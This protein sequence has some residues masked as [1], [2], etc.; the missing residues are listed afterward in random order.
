MIIKIKQ[1]FNRSYFDK[2][3]PFEY[4]LYMVFFFVTLIIST[5]SATTNT[6]LG[7]GVFG[8]VIQHVYNLCCVVILFISKEKRMRIYKPH[9]ILTTHLYL[10][11]MFFQTAGYQGT[12]LLFVPLCLFLLCIVFFNRLRKLLIITCGLIFATCSLLEYHFPQLVVP[13]QGPQAQIIDLLVAMLITFSGMAALAVYV[14][15]SY[16]GETNRIEQLLKELELKNQELEETSI[17]D[18]LTGAYNRRFLSEFLER[19]LKSCKETNSHMFVFLADIDYF[20]NVNDK[21]G[22]GT[23]DEVLKTFVK[24]IRH[25]IRPSDVVARYGGEEFVGVLHL[26]DRDTAFTV[27]ERVRVAVQALEFRYDLRI[28]ASFGVSMSR[29]EDTVDSLL[30]RADNYMYQAKQT[31]RNKVV[32]NQDKN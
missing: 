23:G 26:E 7:A 24:T 6:L 1:F 28:T 21:F 9:L 22:H 13:F 31:G 19:E 27:V 4:R 14:S 12:S 29:A 30:E 15:K 11:F 10:P 25:S 32:G 8:V 3:L 20:K 2:A 17:R 18:A 5:I 16:K